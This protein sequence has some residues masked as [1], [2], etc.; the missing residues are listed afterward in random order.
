MGIGAAIGGIV[1]SIIT[2]VA[3]FGAADVGLGAAALGAD[4]AAFGGADAAALGLGAGF[5]SDA[6]IAGGAGALGAADAA[7]AGGL[8]LGA[9][10]ASDAAIAGGAGGGLAA[11]DVAAGAG[12]GAG[13]LISDAAGGAT[14]AEGVP[15]ASTYGPVS[16]FATDAGAGLAAGT[17]SLVSD[18]AG[19]ATIAEG[20][21]LTSTF[22]PVSSFGTDAGGLAAGGG[23]A[24]DAGPSLAPGLSSSTPNLS[25]NAT[26]LGGVTANAPGPGALSFTP[27]TP[28]AA[29]SI[30]LTSSF[31]NGPGGD[32]FSGVSDSAPASSGV[33]A[34]PTEVGSQI[35]ADA[36]NPATYGTTSSFGTGDATGAVSPATEAGT[37]ATGQP[38]WLGRQWNSFTGGVNDVGTFLNSPTGKVISTGV[39]GLGLVNSLMQANTPN[40]IPGQ[41]QLQATANALGQTGTSLIAPNATA[42]SGV[43]G[44]AQDQS[45]TLE[46]YL[47]TGTLPPAVQASLDRAT[48]SAITDIKAKYAAKGMPPDSSA[49]Q[50]DIAAVQQS[51]VIQGGTLAAQLYSQGVSQ[52]QLAGQIY[53]GLVGAG[54]SAAAA[55]LGGQESIVA[56]NTALNT[57]VNNAIANLSS[58]LGGGSRAII[59]GNTVTLPT[60]A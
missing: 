3:G 28:S 1:D 39:S 44:Q 8:G 31:A 58:A 36:A 60:A 16:A 40:P 5:A 27:P 34:A 20:A 59:N 57:G 53:Q 41:A 13:G 19:G 46:N 23:T 52:E 24:A 42:A 26:S 35:T 54:T 12:L 50:Q 56:T 7:A 45:R 11:G 18:A 47:N 30:D 10:F 17:P 14:I 4:A 9:G 55:G 38:G 43:A 51:S 48:Q 21:P 29:Q 37:D 2:A 49:E 33:S 32:V 22:G 15:L 25:A 6:A